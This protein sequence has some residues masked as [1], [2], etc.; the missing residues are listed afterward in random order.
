MSPL[1]RAGRLVPATALAAIAVLAGDHR[2]SARAGEEPECR[3][4]EFEVTPTDDLQMVVWLEDTAGNYVDTIF[5]TRKTGTYGLGN[6]PGMMT[7]NSGP[8]WPYGRRTTTFPVWAHRHG[9]TFPLIEFQDGNDD[10]L[11]HALGESSRERFYCRPIRADE[12]LWDATSCASTV[13]TDKG[14]LSGDG[15]SLYPPRSDITFDSAKDHPSVET[16]ADLN[17][18]DAVS[19]ATPPGGERY[20]A[21]WPVP[22]SVPN[23]E[24]V[25]WLEVSKEFDQNDVYD[26]CNQPC[27]PDPPFEPGDCCTECPDCPY[28]SPEGIPWA[29][30]GLAY[31]GQPSLVYSTPISLSEARVVGT[32]LDYVGYGDPEGEDGEIRPPDATITTGMAGSG[33]D[34][35]EIMVD[36]AEPYRLRVSAFPSPDETAPDAPGTVT[37]HE[38]TGTDAQ[39]SFTAPGDD[40][41][42]GEVA[43]YEIRYVTGADI[44]AGNFY[45]ATEAVVTLERVAP[46]EL[47]QVLI[48]ELLPRTAYTVGVRA[49][50]ECRNVGPITV[51]HLETPRPEPGTVDACFI[52]TAAYG[53]LMA[54]EV[55]SLRAFR[56]AALRSNLPGEIAVEGYYT[57]GPLLARTIA[58]SET[59]RRAARA[60][61]A[62]LTARVRAA[63]F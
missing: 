21:S 44:D 48:R 50:D 54:G 59:L 23:G 3:V 56:D 4:V 5:I 19:T 16:M 60:A 9:M 14:V 55:A 42:E 62:P 36:D 33:A 25:L 52:A 1:S 34:R 11:S 51:F 41:L 7:F 37:V 35:L 28:P 17:P 40:G 24:Y 18:F 15:V 26:S 46:G 57:F 13:Y 45:D 43:G 8:W 63:G 39:V 38:V 27:A 6:R 12:E 31:R 30:Y 20:V 29:E 49:F 10:N 58:P 53:S 47:Q 22:P 2:G 61:L 32:T